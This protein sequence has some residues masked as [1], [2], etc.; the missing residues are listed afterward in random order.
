MAAAAADVAQHHLY[1]KVLCGKF[2]RSGD[3]QVGIPLTAAGPA[4]FADGG[5]SAGGHPV[6]E[7]PGFAGKGC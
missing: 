3:G 6:G 7:T 1:V 5:K 2:Y 4:V